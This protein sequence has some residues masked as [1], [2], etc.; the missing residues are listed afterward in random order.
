[1]LCHLLP[2]PDA[3]EEPTVFIFRVEEY[4]KK[5]FLCPSTLKDKGTMLILNVGKHKLPNTAVH[6]TRSAS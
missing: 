2:L 4:R 1:M 6:P 5:F 3:S